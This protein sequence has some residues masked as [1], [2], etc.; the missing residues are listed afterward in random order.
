MCLNADDACPGPA[1]A[2]SESLTVARYRLNLVREQSP[3][4][5]PV[6]CGQAAAAARLAHQLV[7]GADREVMGALLVDV[8]NRATGYTI[9]YV[10]TLSRTLA[11]PRGLLLPALLANAA[12]II[13]FH[14]HPSGDPSPSADDLVFTK[15]VAEAATLLGLE[16]LDH[17]VLGEE[18]HFVSLRERGW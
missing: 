13:L 15:R 10:G 17:L 11:E 9:A 5:E 6:A 14:N 8:R 3:G 7:R 4:Y 18:P 16:V 1:L 12:S 2:I